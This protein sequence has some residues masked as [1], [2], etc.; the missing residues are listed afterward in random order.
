MEYKQYILIRLPQNSESVKNAFDICNRR[1]VGGG[2]EEAST[3]LW[4]STKTHANHLYV[5]K[6]VE[7]YI[8]KDKLKRYGFYVITYHHL[9]IFE[10]QFVL[11]HFCINRML[12]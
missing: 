9:N 10:A 3:G 12:K 2:Y 6:V 5:V 4:V 11:H 1:F 8:L 7:H